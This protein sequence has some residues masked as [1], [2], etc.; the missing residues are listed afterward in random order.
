MANKL[1]SNVR[2][3]SELCDTVSGLNANLSGTVTETNKAL[4]KINAIE[5]E[6]V[7]QNRAICQKNAVC[8]CKSSELQCNGWK[9]STINDQ[10]QITTTNEELQCQPS[11]QHP[12][13][14]Y[15]RDLEQITRKVQQFYGKFSSACTI[16][17]EQASDAID[18]YKRK[19]Y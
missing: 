11:Y 15:I 19:K 6:S 13:K 3:I 17:I 18:F 14:D 16:A 5:R 7:A 8:D 10:E 9:L 2:E 4:A 12:L 1:A